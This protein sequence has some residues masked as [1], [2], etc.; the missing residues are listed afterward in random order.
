VSGTTYGA[1]APVFDAVTGKMTSQ[2]DNLVNSPIASACFSCHDTD[3][4]KL[5]MVEIGNGSIYLPRSAALL[6]KETCLSCHGAG[7]V[8]DVQVVHQ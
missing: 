4:A 8:A 5:H 3:K 2:P 1:A 6:R 7:K